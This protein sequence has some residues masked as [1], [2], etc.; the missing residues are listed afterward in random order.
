[1]K[2]RKRK[3]WNSASALWMR[4]KSEISAEQY[5]E[6]YHHAGHAFDEPWHTL[7]FRAEGA[8]EYTALLFIPD[9]ENLFDLFHPER[10]NQVKLYVNRVF[11]SD[12]LDNLMPRY[13]APEGRMSN[14]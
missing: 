11:I 8:V 2:R 4:P 5:T 9:P 10:K 14:T 12:Q 7:H 6:F 13:A 3:P 1:M